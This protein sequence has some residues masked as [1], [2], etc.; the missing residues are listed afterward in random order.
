MR[1]V[2]CA[3]DAYNRQP[4][5]TKGKKRGLVLLCAALSLCAGHV[6]ATLYFAHQIHYKDASREPC[7][8]MKNG[9]QVP[10]SSLHLCVESHLSKAGHRRPHL[11]ELARHFHRAETGAVLTIPQPHAAQRQPQV[12]WLVTVYERGLTFSLLRTPPERFKEARDRRVLTLSARRAASSS[13][14]MNKDAIIAPGQ[15]TCLRQR[16]LASASR[17]SSPLLTWTESVVVAD[18][19]G[20]TS[21]SPGGGESL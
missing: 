1:Q 12:S 2:L 5:N 11:Q 21:R 16:A 14:R 3:I 8:W 7:L 9:R 18:I 20:E 15:S 13:A 17:W 10:R 4:M 6:G 19:K